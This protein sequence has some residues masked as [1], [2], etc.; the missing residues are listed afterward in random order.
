MC[1]RLLSLEWTCEWDIL[2]LNMLVK[3]L[4]PNN[5]LYHYSLKLTH[6][7]L[8]FIFTP[9]EQQAENCWLFCKSF[10]HTA[11]FSSRSPILDCVPHL[12]EGSAIDKLLWYLISL[13]M[14]PIDHSSLSWGLLWR[15]TILPCNF[16]SLQFVIYGESRK[17]HYLCQAVGSCIQFPDTLAK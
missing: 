16:K 13:D 5:I 11:E 2:R 8:M 4:L 15:K 3:Y 10:L 12:I 9:F 14:V 17:W 1:V 7:V 6:A